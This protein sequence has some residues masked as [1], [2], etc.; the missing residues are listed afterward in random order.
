MSYKIIKRLARHLLILPS[1]VKCYFPVDVMLRIERAIADSEKTHCGEICFVV[2][3]NLDAL[4]ILR[5][6]TAKQRSVEV[7]SQFHVWDTAQNNGV[8]IYLLLADRDF[9]ILADRGIHQHVGKD[10]WE[11]ICKEMETHFRQGDFEEG[12]RH[13]IAKIGEHLMTHFPSIVDKINELP[14]EP[15]VI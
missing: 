3:S 13:G 1:R 8:L 5:K 7:F 10:G 4:D 12:V 14:N 15:I 2:E 11:S 6:K 9:E